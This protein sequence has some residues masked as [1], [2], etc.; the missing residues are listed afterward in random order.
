VSSGGTCHGIPCLQSKG[1]RW[2][3]GSLLSPACNPVAVRRT[4]STGAISRECDTHDTASVAI[5]TERRSDPGAGRRELR[6]GCIASGCDFSIDSAGRV[7]G[8]GTVSGAGDCE[9]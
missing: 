3:V 1:L 9:F 2:R 8:F 7:G 6:I 5:G 4:A